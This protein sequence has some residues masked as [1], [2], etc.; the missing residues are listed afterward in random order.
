[1]FS[2][3]VPVENFTLGFFPEDTNCIFGWA[4]KAVGGDQYIDDAWFGKYCNLSP[5]ITPVNHE[6]CYVTEWTSSNE[7]IVDSVN[8]KLV[9]QQPGTTTITALLSN[10]MSATYDFVVVNPEKLHS[11]YSKTFIVSPG[12]YCL[13]SFMPEQTGEYIR[14]C[15]VS[16]PDCNTDEYVELFDF[17]SMLPDHADRED[18]YCIQINNV[19]KDRLLCKPGDNPYSFYCTNYMPFYDGRPVESPAITLTVCFDKYT[20]FTDVSAD[21]FYYEPVMWALDNNITTGATET[22]FNPNGECLRAQV[23]TFLWRVAGCPE[24]TASDN[25]FVDVKENDFYYNAVLWAVENGITNGADATH[26]N[27]NGVCNRAQVV[28]F[29]YRAFGN[30]AVVATENPF[31]DVPAGAFYAAP[32]LWAVENGITNGLSA[33]EFGPN[34]NCNRAQI[35]TFLYRAYN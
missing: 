28:T 23:V 15:S 9:L 16:I 20:P 35:V 13:F 31:T 24:P 1:M 14:S 22:T 34:T 27:P 25:P 32:V 18:E 26:F 4:E 3:V 11:G 2:E 21:S 12:E 29:L 10:G 19:V 17:R 7:N 6:D 5:I 8:G 33:T 30:P